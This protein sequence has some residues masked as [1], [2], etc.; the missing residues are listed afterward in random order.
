MLRLVSASPEEFDAFALSYP[1][2]N[3]YQQAA[4]ATFRSQLGWQTHLLLAKQNGVAVGAL[5]LAGKKGR[6]EVAMGPLFDFS[7]AALAQELLDLIS[8]YVKKLGGFEVAAYPY[9]LYQTRNST[10][11]VQSGPDSEILELFKNSGWGHKG[12][13]TE[14]DFSAF[15]WLFTK[16]LSNIHT[17][18]ELLSSYRQTTRQTVKKLVHEDYSIKKLSYDE[19]PIIKQLIDSSND[20][21]EIN[22]RP[23]SYYQYFFKSFGDKIEFLVVYHKNETPISAGVFIHHP[24][25]LAY[26]LSGT[27]SRYRHLYGG[28]FLQ[29][30][31]MKKAVADG[32]QRYN[33]FGVKGVFT[34]NPLLV[35]KSGFRGVVEEYIGGFTKVVNPLKFFAFKVL[36]LP[37]AVLRKILQ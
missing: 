34:K 24:S 3:F 31:V 20:R 2:G 5:L 32:V 26:F 16:D 27:D 1:K 8:N 25:E 28:H 33:F 21:N 12:F 6:Y 36:R 22:N 18:A 19:L 17:E 14:Y 10:G 29:H 30:T 9:E 35:Y 4:M 11:V 7:N 15:R 23:L 13:T 37:K